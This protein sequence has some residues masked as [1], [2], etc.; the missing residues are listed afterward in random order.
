MKKLLSILMC[1]CLLLGCLTAYATETEATEA[2]ETTEG[3]ESTEGTD[4]NYDNGGSFEDATNLYTMQTTG[5]QIALPGMVKVVSEQENEQGAIVMSL[6]IDGRN[7]CQISV[8]MTMVEEYAGLT[9]TSM[10]EEQLNALIENY[11][12]NYEC[13]EAPEL[14]QISDDP[15]YADFNPLYFTG[16]GADNNQYAVYVGVLGGLQLTVALVFTGETA[17]QENLGVLLNTYIQMF[18][19]VVQ[20]SQAE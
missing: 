3:T 7:D 14:I 13:K 6:S 20:A 18:D 15:E 2:P 8:V 5:F 12:S 11:A 10:P 19:A 16:K 4:E 1:L 9:L 17:D